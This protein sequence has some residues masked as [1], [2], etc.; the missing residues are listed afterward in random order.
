MN[1]KMYQRRQKTAT[2]LDYI[3]MVASMNAK[4]HGEWFF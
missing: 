1:T 3:E 2:M 4:R